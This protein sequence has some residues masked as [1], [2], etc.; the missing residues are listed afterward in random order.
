MKV[1]L[2]EHTNYQGEA[3]VFTSEQ[4]KLN[5]FNDLTSS[6]IIEEVPY[7]EVF[8]GANYT[9][10]SKAIYTNMSYYMNSI[11]VRND[12]IKS[13]RVPYGLKLM[14]YE[15]DGFKGNKRTLVAD[16]PDLGSFNNM[17][18]SFRAEPDLVDPEFMS[19][20]VRAR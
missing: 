4:A 7:A 10:A 8:E 17:T 18:S 6:M 11:T 20:P 9:G 16:T 14:L 15:H 19:Y 1:T 2:Y 3:R 13:V 12:S 5:N